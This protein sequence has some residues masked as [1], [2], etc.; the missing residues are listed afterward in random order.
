MKIPLMDLHRQYETLRPQINTAIQNILDTTQFI[1][2]KEKEQF[3]QE[4]AHMMGTKHCVG[5]ANG[6]DS[7]FL[8]LK[9][10]GVGAGDEVVVP[11]NSFIASS[12]AVTATGARV[13]FCDA[14]EED[15]LINLDHVENLLAKRSKKSGGKIKAIMPVHIYGQMVDMPRLMDLAR[16]YE[17]LVLEDS[18]QAHL[19]E[20]NGVKAGAYGDAGSFSFYPGKNLGAYGDAGAIITNN[21]DLAV[22]L[23]KIANHGRISKYDHDMEG[24]NSRLDTL[25]A[26]VLRVKLPHL[27]KW[28]QLRQEKAAYYD[29]LL[30]GA[31]NVILPFSKKNG[32]HVYHLYVIRVQNRDKIHAG[33]EAAGI[34]TV[35][36]YPKALHEL[37]AYKYLGHKPEDFPVSH[38]LQHEILSLPL[39]PEILPNEQEFVV[40][41]LKKL[42]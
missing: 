16:K 13:V 14:R 9:T 31:P 33:M 36:H 12:E 23:R 18:A 30:T 42:L 21:P 32:S 39:F 41:T 37:A 10:M 5:V 38:K 22:N 17:V 19:A 29:K 20:I 6:T 2:G 26:A 4:Y 27:P 11:A 40:E 28:T 1:G 8:M 3:E 15:F 35:I 34:Q 7:L 25:Q 24:F